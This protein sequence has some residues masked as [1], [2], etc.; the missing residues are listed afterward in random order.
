MQISIYFGSK[1]SNLMQMS[2]I[3]GC[4]PHTQA[5]A[6]TANWQSVMNSF[7]FSKTQW[8]NLAL[9]MIG[10]PRIQKYG[11]AQAL[12]AENVLLF[13]CSFFSSLFM[14]KTIFRFL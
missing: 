11:S 6:V 4:V 5:I 12:A 1:L 13:D 8:I 14:P 9:V 10:H 2:F 3:I 7:Y